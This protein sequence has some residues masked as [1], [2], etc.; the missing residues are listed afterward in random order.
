MCATTHDAAGV[1]AVGIPR[2]PDPAVNRLMLPVL[3]IAHVV[4]VLDQVV[5]LLRDSTTS[6]RQYNIISSTRSGTHRLPASC[7]SVRCFCVHGLALHGHAAHRELQ[8]HAAGRRAAV[9]AVS[10]AAAKLAQ[11]HRELLAGPARA[12]ALHRQ[13][14]RVCLDARQNTPHTFECRAPQRCALHGLHTS[15]PELAQLITKQLTTLL[16]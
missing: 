14:R 1:A 6:V 4:E 2:P 12:V 10:H 9:A 5:Q 11:H 3:C 15:L 8:P 7:A 16:R 13:S